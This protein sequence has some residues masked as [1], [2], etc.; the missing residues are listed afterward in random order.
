MI[1]GALLLI[2]PVGTN[3][4]QTN[5]FYINDESEIPHETN[6]WYSRS[7]I[8]N[9]KN[10][11]DSRPAEN[12]PEGHWGNVTEGFQLSIRL[13]KSSFTNGEIISAVVTLRNVSDKILWYP[14]SYGPDKETEIELVQSPSFSP[15]TNAPQ[16]ANFLER[17][18]AVHAG[19]TGYWASTVG[20]QRKFEVVLNE[21]IDLSTNGEYIVQARRKIAKSSERAFGD[22][23]SG[24]IIFH[25]GDP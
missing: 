6:N 25:I 9:A 14:V 5:S 23:T 10:A 2:V 8:E 3:L 16:A 15:Q 18:K 21:V 13:P 7:Q 17:V 11:L 19:S 20:T 1:I 24:K 12:D 4:A 22:V